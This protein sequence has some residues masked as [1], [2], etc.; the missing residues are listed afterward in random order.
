MAKIYICDICGEKTPMSA[1]YI[2]RFFSILPNSPADPSTSHP[3]EKEICG[4]CLGKI[5]KLI[6][7]IQKSAKKK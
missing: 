2:L 6:K 7:D 4:V 3:E 1:L 5:E